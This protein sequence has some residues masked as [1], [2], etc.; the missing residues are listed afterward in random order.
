[1]N[2]ELVCRVADTIEGLEI[3][4][5]VGHFDMCLYTHECG[6]PACV[7]G[8]TCFLADGDALATAY[9][10]M[11]HERARMLLGL[12]EDT[13]DSLFTPSCRQWVD[14][15]RLYKFPPDKVALVLRHLAATGTLEWPIAWR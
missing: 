14:A 3:G 8:W 11:I 2:S 15:P 10:G 7:A 1:M 13:A 5:K 6:A 9:G 4:G 12:D